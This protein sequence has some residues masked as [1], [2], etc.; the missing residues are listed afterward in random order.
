MKLPINQSIYEDEGRDVLW[1]DDINL[2]GE[3]AQLSGLRTAP[4][5]PKGKQM[6]KHHHAKVRY[7]V[8]CGSEPAP[9]SSLQLSSEVE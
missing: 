9:A 5:T 3:S 6:S 8:P 1:E 2:T 4:H 7:W